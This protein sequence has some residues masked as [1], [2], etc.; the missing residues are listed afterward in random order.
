MNAPFYMEITLVQKTPEFAAFQETPEYKAAGDLN[1]PLK[2]YKFL[3]QKTFVVKTHLTIPQVKRACGQST[4]RDVFVRVLTYVPKTAF[5]LV[6]ALGYFETIAGETLEERET[7]RE[8][9]DAKIE[10]D[11]KRRK[12]VLA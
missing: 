4:E 7:F 3:A 6:V 8:C 1:F 10:R 2:H 12:T 9:R 11:A 5:S